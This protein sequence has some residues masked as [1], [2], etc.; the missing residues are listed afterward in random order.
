MKL[1]VEITIF[2]LLTG[3]GVAPDAQPSHTPTAPAPCK[4]DTVYVEIGSSA[5]WG[6]LPATDSFSLPD[7]PVYDSLRES[8]LW[9]WHSVNDTVKQ[10]ARVIRHA[11]HRT[12]TVYFPETMYRDTATGRW[13][14]VADSLAAQLAFYEQVKRRN[15][16]IVYVILGSIVLLFGSLFLYFTKPWKY[17]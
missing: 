10:P 1:L 17:A 13:V 15:M 14:V 2:T 16:W 8:E 7:Y 3:C 6:V 4:P 12:D 11:I 9:Y 5:W